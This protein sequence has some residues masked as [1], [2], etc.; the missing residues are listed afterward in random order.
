V[1]IIGSIGS[2]YH[3]SMQQIALVDSETG[4]Y[5]ERQLSHSAGEAEQ[6]YRNL[7]QRGVRMR[8]GDGGHR[9]CALVRTA[10]G[11]TGFR[12]LDRRPCGDQGRACSQAEDGPR[13]CSTAFAAVAERSFCARMGSRSKE[14]GSASDGMD[15]GW[16][17]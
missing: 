16:C 3:P 8:V 5:V 12:A 17:R 14:S 15:I 10:D 2:D 1:I 7:K 13:G 11:G 6:F 9:A 4:E